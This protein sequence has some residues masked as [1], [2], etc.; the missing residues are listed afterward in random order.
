MG[1]DKVAAWVF[2]APDATIDTPGVGRRCPDGPGLER[3]GTSPRVSTD[4]TPPR[5]TRSSPRARPSSSRGATGTPTTST[6][7]CPA[8]SGSCRCRRWPRAARSLRCRTP[9]PRFGIPAKSENKDA[10]AL[11]L[12]FLSSDEARQIA[13]DN[14]FMPSGAASQPAPHG[15]VRRRC[16]MTCVAGFTAVSA[17]N[18]QV[19]FVQ[20]ATAGIS[21]Q[22]WNPESQLLLGGKD[23]ARRVRHE[24]PVE[25]RGGAGPM[26]T[27]DDMTAVATVV[28]ETVRRRR[29][30]ARRRAGSG[31]WQAPDRGRDGSSPFPPW[32][33]TL[34]FVLYPVLDVDPVLVLRLGRD[35]RVRRRSASTTTRGCSPTPSCW[36]RSWHAFFLIIFFTIIPCHRRP[37]RGL[38]G[39]GDQVAGRR[40]R[41][42]ARCC[43]CPQIIPGAAAAIAWIWMYSTN[44]AVNQLLVR[45]RSRVAAPGPG[46][47]TSPGRCRRSA[48]S[49][50]GSRPGSARC[51]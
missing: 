48:S 42:R 9:R 40:W 43:S 38:A 49:A 14:G 51:C 37:G 3:P 10:A 16:S 6:R 2:N 35:Q 12:N 25:V 17:A 34:V 41:W 45:H 13:V 28:D 50:P 23:D 46:S 36:P 7:P 44:G 24:R 1:P 4:W 26:S 19:P 32:S 29:R 15:Q 22:G 30:D 20:N 5:P 8:R 47:A 31:G 39:P 33:C 11:F 18:G 27:V 21:N